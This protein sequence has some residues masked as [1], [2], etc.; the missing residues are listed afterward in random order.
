[1]LINNRSSRRNNELTSYSLSR[2][3]VYEPLELGT[4]IH[5]AHK[6]VIW[7]ILFENVNQSSFHHISEC[8]LDSFLLLII[9]YRE[10]VSIVSSTIAVTTRPIAISSPS[11]MLNSIN[12]ST[13]ERVM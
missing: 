12:W 4:P 5:V 11:L 6:N 7:K 2:Q 1:M 13:S 3:G 9:V 10:C 8:G